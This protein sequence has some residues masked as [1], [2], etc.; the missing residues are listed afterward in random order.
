M[1]GSCGDY[2]SFKCENFDQTAEEVEFNTLFECSTYVKASTQ[3]TTSDMQDT[4]TGVPHFG[5]AATMLFYSAS[6]EALSAE[7]S[8]SDPKLLKTMPA[9]FNA[10]HIEGFNASHVEGVPSCFKGSPPSECKAG[11]RKF[12]SGTA[13]GKDLQACGNAYAYKCSVKA[14]EVGLCAY[15]TGGVGSTFCASRAAQAV[16]KFVDNF[17]DKYLEKPIVTVATTIEDASVSVA[18]HVGH[19]FLSLF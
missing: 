9:G 10:S 8:A 3:V 15:L 4:D 13:T 5:Y 6:F 18:K 7:L 1:E 11:L 12:M 16:Y 14:I 2:A 17:A 19:F